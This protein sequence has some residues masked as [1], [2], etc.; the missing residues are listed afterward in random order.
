MPNPARILEVG[1]AEGAQ[2]LL[3]ANQFPNA[4]VTGIEI[5][6][7]AFERARGNLKSYENRVELVNADVIEY[8]SRLEE[9]AFD[10]CIWSETVYYI[11]ARLSLNDTYEF[12]NRM[13]RKLRVGGLMVMANTVDLSE[14]I[15]EW[16]VTRRPVIDCYY[17]MLSRLITPVIRSVYVEEKLGRI[18]E[19]QIWAFQR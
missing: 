13:V 12:L 19:Y 3:L 17:T 11:G 10:A 7:I 16:I 18:F 9:N 4:T 8:E 5:S 15:P 6:S 14:D 2:T 1:S